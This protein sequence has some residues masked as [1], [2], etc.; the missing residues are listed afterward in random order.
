MEPRIVWGW[1]NN[2]PWSCLQPLATVHHDHVLGVSVTRA[3]A[4]VIQMFGILS[5]RSIGRGTRQA[6]RTN[7]AGA[8][9]I[10]LEVSADGVVRSGQARDLSGEV[11]MWRSDFPGS[12][13]A[14]CS[15]RD[16]SRGGRQRRRG[17]RRLA[18]LAAATCSRRVFSSFPGTT[19]R[20][21]KGV[22]IS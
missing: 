1:S 2:P 12:H 15:A 8:H 13:L 21:G 16:H 17:F 20:K 5:S 10:A 18:S 6:S 3:P 4:R 22:V 9:Q 7:C 14:V 19:P 11:V